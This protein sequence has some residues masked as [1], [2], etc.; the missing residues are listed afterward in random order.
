MTEPRPD[1]VYFTIREV[2]EQIGVV[3]ATI[4]N[5]EKHGLFRAKRSSNGYRIFDFNDIARLREIKQRSKDE[6][7]GINALRLLFSTS[8]DDAVEKDDVVVSR[9]LLSEKWK[10]FR[11]ERGYLLEEVAQAIGISASYLSKIENLQAA[12]VSLSVL[13]RLA[14]FYGENLLYYVN[15][16]QEERFLV[17]RDERERVSIGIPG[18]TV[19]SVSAMSKNTLSP[20]LYT[21][22]PGRGRDVPSAHS[23]E[24]FIYVISGEMEF[25]LGEDQRFLLRAGDALTFSS[26]KPHRW[27]NCGS[28][29][30]QLL[31]VYTPLVR[32]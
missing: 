31:W 20:M 24:E 14:D 18:I 25:I 11:L 29:R 10:E 15:G 6:G 3:P 1:E 21:V 28:A 5:W 30:A 26:L 17:R 12:N 32:S 2:A 16:P 9:R 8:R 22:E 19:E 23:G 7:M 4:R 13:Q 27:R